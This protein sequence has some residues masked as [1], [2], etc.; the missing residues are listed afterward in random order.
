MFLSP[1][2]VL[3]TTQPLAKKLNGKK[4]AEQERRT[5]WLGGFVFITLRGND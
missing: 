2:Q 5:G 1:P 3:P 4:L